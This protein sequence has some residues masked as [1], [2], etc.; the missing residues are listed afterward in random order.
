MNSMSGLWNLPPKPSETAS[1]IISSWLLC[2]CFSYFSLFSLLLMCRY[3][4]RKPCFQCVGAI[5]ALQFSSYILDI[6][7]NTESYICLLLIMLISFIMNNVY[8]YLA[9]VTNICIMKTSLVMKGC[10]MPFAVTEMKFPL[11]FL[12]FYLNVY[13]S[14][15]NLFLR[16]P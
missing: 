5:A 2:D 15:Y 1:G 14:A 12:W 7:W 4:D 11:E 3:I 8:Q 10:I 13:S 6:V 9:A 16:N